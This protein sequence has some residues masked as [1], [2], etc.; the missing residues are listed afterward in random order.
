M[1]PSEASIQDVLLPTLDPRII[2]LANTPLKKWSEVNPQKY[3]LLDFRGRP[4]FPGMTWGHDTQTQEAEDRKRKGMKQDASIVKQ[5][6]RLGRR[7]VEKRNHYSR[8]E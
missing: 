6:R 5:K 7:E 3:N 1:R 8:V 4:A 2:S